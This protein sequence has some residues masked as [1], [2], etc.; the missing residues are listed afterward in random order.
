MINPVHQSS[1]TLFFYEIFLSLFLLLFDTNRYLT[2]KVWD[3]RPAN[4]QDKIVKA[5]LMETID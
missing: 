3:L 4:E 1:D 2:S 5:T